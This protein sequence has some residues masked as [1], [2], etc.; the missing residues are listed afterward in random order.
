MSGVNTANATGNMWDS[1][2][3]GQQNWMN[4]FQNQQNLGANLMTNATNNA[5]QMTENIANA[6][7]QNTLNKNAVTSAAWSG[8]SQGLFDFVPGLE[9]WNET[10]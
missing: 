1:M 4:Q 7:I 3:K 6:R 5:G 10:A 9:G 8:L 2:F